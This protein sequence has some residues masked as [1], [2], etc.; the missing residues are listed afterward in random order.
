MHAS[1][2]FAA[3]TGTVA[4]WITILKNKNLQPLQL[5]QNIAAKILTHMRQMQMLSVTP[6]LKE[7][8]W[9]PL[10][11]RKNHTDFK[12]ATLAVC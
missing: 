9:T 12:T 1:V 3:K 7:L 10:S 6:V 5:M 11:K 2:T 8:H 4:N